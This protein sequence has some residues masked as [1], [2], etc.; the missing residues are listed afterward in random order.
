M[1]LCVP[2]E[3]SPGILTCI[4]GY[5]DNLS[6]HLLG[7][8]ITNFVGRP[9]HEFELARRLSNAITAHAIDNHPLGQ[10]SLNS[11]WIVAFAVVRELAQE[12][13]TIL[14]VLDPMLGNQVNSFCY[15]LE[16]SANDSVRASHS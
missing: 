10:Q 2:T 13:D 9:G 3:A 15:Y 14:Q 12:V 1:V 7:T 11:V 4:P 16:V 6:D 8:L 5:M